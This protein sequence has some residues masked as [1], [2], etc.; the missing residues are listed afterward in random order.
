MTHYEKIGD[1]KYKI[2]A[3]C[4]HP[5]MGD[6]NTCPTRYGDCASCQYCRVSMVFKDYEA[7]R[8]KAKE[9]V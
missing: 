6:D 3:G 7:L 2:E 1:M 8:D 5:D 9:A 4:F